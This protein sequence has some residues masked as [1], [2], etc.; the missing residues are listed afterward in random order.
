MLL[1]KTR[2]E[3]KK[4]R[5]LSPALRVI[6]SKMS[7]GDDAEANFCSIPFFVLYRSNLILQILDLGGACFFGGFFDERKH[8]ERGKQKS[9]ADIL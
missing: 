8:A 3:I 7:Y 5:V 2:S 4:Q 1:P 6:E 9:E